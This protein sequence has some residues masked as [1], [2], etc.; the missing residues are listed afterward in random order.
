[1]QE[2]SG[3]QHYIKKLDERF[4]YKEM[5]T[6]SDVQRFTGID[7]RSAAKLFPFEGNYISKA[8]LAEAM[9]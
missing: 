6:K 5:L 4:P 9:S 1:M 7:P 8:K 3:F 2:K